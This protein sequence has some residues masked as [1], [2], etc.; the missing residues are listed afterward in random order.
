MGLFDET[1]T[2]TAGQDPG[3]T[4]TSGLGGLISRS[5]L[6]NKAVAEGTINPNNV[7]LQ[8]FESFVVTNPDIVDPSI[9]LS[10]LKTTTDANI[11]G[12]I[13]DFP[14][15]QYE[16]YNPNRLSDLMNLYSVGLPT[17][18]TDTAQIPGAVDTLVDVGGGGGQDQVTGDSVA[19]F[20]PGVTPGP[21]G[22]IGL[23]PDMDIDPQDFAQ[24]DYGIYDPTAT[25]GGITGD[26]IEVGIPDNESGFVD[27][28]GTI[29]GAPVV[30]NFS[31]P[32]TIQ[33]DLSQV[34]VDGGLSAIDEERLAGYTPSFETPEQQQGFLQDVLGRAGQTV[35]NALTELGKVPGAV[36]DFANQTVDIFGQKIKM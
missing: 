5:N 15:I 35:D 23:D 12:N 14:G 8:D 32:T 6:Y 30:G 16:A 9:D 13:T 20:D 31:E 4:S 34:Q 18:A 29:G 7:S 33:G 3:D 28:L 24:E 19:G 22:F 26:P 11:L 10:G 21:S 36:V 17:L 27:P 25:T 2:L 1:A